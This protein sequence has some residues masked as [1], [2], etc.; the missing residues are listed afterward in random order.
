MVKI[1]Y[2]ISVCNE[3]EELNNLLAHLLPLIQKE[4]EVIILIDNTNT[5]EHILDVIRR[6]EYSGGIGILPHGLNKDFANHKNKF[7]EKAKGDYIFQ[8]DADEIPTK[9]LIENLPYILEQNPDIDLYAVPRINIVDGITEEDIKKW[10]WN[11]NNMGWLN[12]PD[13]QQRI[14]KNN[15][16]IRWKNK[17]HEVL[18]GAQTAS[19]LPFENTTDFTILHKKSID[20]QRKQNELYSTI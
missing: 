13:A 10:G 8:I 2:A 14:F 11:Q 7:L 18:E 9:I 1:S 5:T 16:K 20:K 17:I 12:F 19:I 15:G 4:D 6:V 3:A